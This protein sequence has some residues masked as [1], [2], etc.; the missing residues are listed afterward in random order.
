MSLKI[1]DNA[2]GTLGAAINNS[3]T[4]IVLTAGHGARFP[5]LGATDYTVATIEDT[6]ANKEK[7][8]I[9]AISGDTLTVVRGWDGDTPRAFAAGSL[10]EIRPCDAIM[11]ALDQEAMAP[12]TAS[13]TDTYTGTLSPAPNGYNADQ[14]YPVIF[15]NTNTSSAPTLNLNGYGAKTI[16]RRDGSGLLQG[17]LRGLHF[18][19][20]N[21]T[22]FV[23]L[24][25]KMTKLADVEQA[26][27]ANDF[28]GDLLLT[29]PYN[30][31]QELA[32]GTTTNWNMNLGH[33]AILTLTGNTTLAVSNL[34]PGVYVL[35]VIQDGTGGRTITWPSVFKWPAGSAPPL[36]TAA[37]ARDLFSFVCD[38]TNLYGSILPDVR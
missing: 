21:G 11:R 20:Y 23:L 3:Q 27:T 38:G 13:G 14:V 1:K 35:H 15:S 29:N 6:A 36:T 19:H 32:F 8:K 4:T 28:P 16:K 18:L 5:S 33:I 31:T 26:D 2:S 30:T 24:D 25:P 34:K 12:I 22:D 10:I 37:N 9:T 7:V 17:D